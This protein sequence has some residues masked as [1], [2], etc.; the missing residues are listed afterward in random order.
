MILHFLRFP[1]SFRELACHSLL[2][3]ENS[4]LIYLEVEIPC[5]KFGNVYLYL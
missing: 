2:Y 5:R 1:M 4:D 3:I